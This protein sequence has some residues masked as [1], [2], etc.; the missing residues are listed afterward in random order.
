M[1]TAV[2][3]IEKCIERTKNN[4]KYYVLVID[5]GGDE[6]AICYTDKIYDTDVNYLFI[7]NADKNRVKVSPICKII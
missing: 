1:F 7:I 4:I 6:K 5:F 2:G 3:K